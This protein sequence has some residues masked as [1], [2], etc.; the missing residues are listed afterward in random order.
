M[1]ICSRPTPLNQQYLSSAL[2]LVQR[3]Q[4]Q[5]A[6]R[7]IAQSR[8]EWQVKCQGVYLNSEGSWVVRNTVISFR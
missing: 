1:S 5:Q 7:K 8:N 3:L 6:E 4:P 2:T